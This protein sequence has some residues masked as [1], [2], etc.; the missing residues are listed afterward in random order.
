M[1]VVSCYRLLGVRSFVL[2]VRSW[3]GNDVPIISTRWMSWQGKES[4]KTQ[5]SPSKVPVLAKGRRISVVSSFRAR[6]PHSAQLWGLRKPGIQADW[7]SVSVGQMGRPGLT[8]CA[9][10]RRPRLVDADTDGAESHCCLMAWAKAS[11]GPSWWLWSPA[12]QS[13]QSAPR[14]LQLPHWPKPG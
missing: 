12:G 11:G 2:E 10:D 7:P 9:P 13:P 4:P 1:D 14:A 5:L 3:S 8:D 6:F